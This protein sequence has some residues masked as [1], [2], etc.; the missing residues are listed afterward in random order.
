MFAAF[1]SITDAAKITFGAI[2]K[3][4]G[5]KAIPLLLALL[6][7]AIILALGSAVPAFAPFV[8]TLF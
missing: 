8:Y 5:W 1:T 4:L 3:S 7:I 2:K 6:T